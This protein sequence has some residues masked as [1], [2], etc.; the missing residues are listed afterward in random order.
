MGAEGQVAIPALLKLLRDTN[1]QLRSA[2][3]HALAIIGRAA[4]R[5]VLAALTPLAR[6][7][8]VAVRREVVN[9]LVRAEAQEA[10]PVFLHAVEDAD[11]GVRVF[12]I[13]GLAWAARQ[14]NKDVIPVLT[15]L[16]RDQDSQ[17]RFWAAKTLG[18]TSPE[19]V[20]EAVQN[21]APAIRADAARALGSLGRKEALPTLRR[22]LQ[23]E[24]PEVRAAAVEGMG[25]FFSPDALPE[26]KQLTSAQPGEHHWRKTLV[27]CRPGDRPAY[28]PRSLAAG[29]KPCAGLFSPS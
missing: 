5:N 22:L 25:H 14:G 27:H 3:G 15:G 13:W 17:V 24:A 2:A 4:P 7:Q 29:A 20:W 12:A 21:Q 1:P 9:T 11:Q 28:N 6:D 16:L 8:D 19:A 18:A 26:L 10:I 23:D